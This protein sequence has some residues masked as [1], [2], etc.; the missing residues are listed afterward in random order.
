MP[1]N[2][3]DQS[4]DRLAGAPDWLP[5]H[6]S[7][8][9]LGA[10]LARYGPPHISEMFANAA[11]ALQHAKLITVE[12]AR[13]DEPDRRFSGSRPKRPDLPA[14]SPASMSSAGNRTSYFSARS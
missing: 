7:G 10:L 3:P 12:L 5:G 4:L 11:D 6:A 13:R 1:V 9:R 8:A 14:R 2:V